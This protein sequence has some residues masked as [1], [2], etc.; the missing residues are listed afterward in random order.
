MLAEAWGA[1]GHC[2]LSSPLWIWVNT[3]REVNPMSLCCSSYRWNQSVWW[4]DIFSVKT[5]WFSVLA[6]T[7]QHIRPSSHAAGSLGEC[8]DQ[9][10]SGA[11]LSVLT[12]AKHIVKNSTLM[13]RT[14]WKKL[15][16]FQFVISGLKRNMLIQDLV[17]FKDLQLSI[18]F[19]VCSQISGSNVPGLKRS[20]VTSLHFPW[21][22]C[23]WS[24]PYCFFKI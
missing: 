4:P 16:W 5:N 2:P 19:K 8:A 12:K 18:E 14:L 9:T 17:T 15:P 7:K 1:C 10:W 3:L 11:L 24:F 6:R 23:H 13:E 21:F 20:T 22:R